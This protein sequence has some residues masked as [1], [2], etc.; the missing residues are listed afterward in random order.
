MAQ[1]AQTFPC[2]QHHIIR[3]ARHNSVFVSAWYEF[4]HML[5]LFIYVHSFIQNGISGSIM[6]WFCTALFTSDY[7]N[8]KGIAIISTLAMMKTY[9]YMHISST[10][11]NYR[12]SS[13]A[14]QHNAYSLQ[15]IIRVHILNVYTC[16]FVKC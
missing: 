13:N 5:A 12:R 4:I 9:T 11:S 3:Y 15:N 6:F 1:W 7:H 16:M 2:K 8:L 10:D 14:P